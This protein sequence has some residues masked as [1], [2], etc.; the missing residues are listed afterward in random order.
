MKMRRSAA[1]RMP[2]SRSARS[3]LR[4]ML[5]AAVQALLST[6]A[7]MA[8][9]RVTR[10]GRIQNGRVIRTFATWSS[11][12]Q[13]RRTSSVVVQSS[14]YTRVS[15]NVTWR[16]CTARRMMWT[17]IQLLSVISLCFSSHLSS[18]RG[19][20]PQPAAWQAQRHRRKHWTATPPWRYT[21][22]RP[23]MNTTAISPPSTPIATCRSGSA[24]ERGTEAG[25]TWKSWPLKSV[26]AFH[27]QAL[28]HR[29]PP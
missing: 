12:A 17:G 27:A 6:E 9:L 22:T 24:I 19:L 4:T 7:A 1:S 2:V 18:A 5:K 13:L 23:M 8:V 14:L 21:L 11:M 26:E 3:H 28:S 29:K 10:L 15:Q 25:S 20:R 16:N